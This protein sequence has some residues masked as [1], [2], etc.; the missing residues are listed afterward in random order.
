M[1]IV[2]STRPAG[3]G[4]Y[5]G[6]E[7]CR[8]CHSGVHDFWRRTSHAGSLAVLRP[9]GSAED[10]NCLRCH[11]T[12]FGE[13]SG[14]S[15]GKAADLAA[16]GCEACHGPSAGHAGRPRDVRTSAGLMAGCPP[17]AVN[18][19]CRLCHTPAHS[20]GFTPGAYFDKVKCPAGA[21]PR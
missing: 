16:V 6:S 18:Q 1:P 5:A 13:E 8:P 21:P 20:P 12:G 2:V 7:A 11:A 17:C 15:G 9:L 10:P 4:T 19:V 14:Y 3:H